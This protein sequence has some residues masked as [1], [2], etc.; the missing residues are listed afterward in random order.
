MTDETVSLDA[1]LAGD[2]AALEE[3][4]ARVQ[5]DVFNLALRMLGTCPTPKTQPRRC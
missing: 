3:L 2:E 4:L 5:D 1:A